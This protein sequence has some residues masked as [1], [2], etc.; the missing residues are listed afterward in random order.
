MFIL[1]KRLKNL[2]KSVADLEKKAQDQQVENSNAN[3][4]LIYVPDGYTYDLI[5]KNCH[6][7]NTGSGLPFN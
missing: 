6:N 1:R 2:E 4:V 7:W 5:I 3:K